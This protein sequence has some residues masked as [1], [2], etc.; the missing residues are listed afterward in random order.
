MHCPDCGNKITAEQQFCRSC[1]ASLWAD[2]AKSFV[3]SPIVGLL[4]AFGGIL[5]ALAGQMLLHQSTVVFVGVVVSVL[6]MMTIA[7]RPMIA[8]KRTHERGR[9]VP[10]R[11]SAIAPAEPTMKLPPINPNDE[12]IP[13]VVDETTRLLN[14]RAGHTADR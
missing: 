8:T 4:L 12:F 3:P 7:L 6:G 9:R 14:E 11:P 2:T 5:V 1:G 10:P 13:S